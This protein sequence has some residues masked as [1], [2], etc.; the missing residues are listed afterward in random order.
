[1][2]GKI[3]IKKNNKKN[4]TEKILIF[5]LLGGGHTGS[6][7]KLSNVAEPAPKWKCGALRDLLPF[8]QFKKREKHSWRS[9]NFNKVE[10]FKPATSLKLTLLHGCFV[11][12]YSHFPDQNFTWFECSLM[13]LLK[14]FWYLLSD[15]LSPLI[16]RELLSFSS[17]SFVISSN[18]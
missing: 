11:L 1:M 6:S 3:K 5:F 8:V 7:L 16:F 14:L 18:A 13:G 15:I 4:N 12:L 17:Q 10:G 9:F 2:L